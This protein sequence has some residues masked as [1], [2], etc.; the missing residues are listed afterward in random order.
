MTKSVIIVKALTEIGRNEHAPRQNYAY[1]FD[2]YTVSDGKATAYFAD[3]YVY[4]CITS[5]KGSVGILFH[6]CCVSQM[7]HCSTV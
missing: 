7:V 1:S 2:V 5:L 6:K 3:V 4:Y